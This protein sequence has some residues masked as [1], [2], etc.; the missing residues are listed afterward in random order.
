M[1]YLSFDKREE[2]PVNVRNEVKRLEKAGKSYGKARGKL[3]L[4][5]ADV[6][7]A[8]IAEGVG[9]RQ[10]DVVMLAGCAKSYVSGLSSAINVWIERN[11]DETGKCD[12][13]QCRAAIGANIGEF[14]RDFAPVKAGNGKGKPPKADAPE[15]DSATD[16]VELDVTDEKGSGNNAPLTATDIL[17]EIDNLENHLEGVPVDQV[18]GEL[19]AARLEEIATHIRKQ[20]AD[21]KVA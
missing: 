15:T 20:I 11:T 17:M 1:K 21:S 12:L 13:N 16:D 2:L 8:G 9:L 14:L 6:L 19:I 18:E 10:V 3:S 4:V 7:L 5:I